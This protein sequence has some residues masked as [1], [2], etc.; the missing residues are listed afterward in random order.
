M[1]S[2]ARNQLNCRKK[3]VCD[4]KILTA[5]KFSYL[6][7]AESRQREERWDRLPKIQSGGMRLWSGC[8]VIGLG[9]RV[10]KI[11]Q[12]CSVTTRGGE[13]ERGRKRGEREGG[14][15]PAADT[16]LRAQTI[17]GGLPSFFFFFCCENRGR[18]KKR[19][20][21]GYRGAGWKERGGE[22][23][24]WESPWLWDLVMK[25]PVENAHSPPPSRFIC[26]PVEHNIQLYRAQVLNK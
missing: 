11:K 4:A 24:F 25:G 18:G 22:S 8:E 21:S 13:K 16:A 19:R 15:G 2:S 23:R 10:A 6:F 5:Q 7:S 26:K 17:G 3:V 20:G 9:A 12:V 14:R 1:V